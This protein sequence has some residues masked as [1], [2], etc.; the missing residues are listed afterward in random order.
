[1]SIRDVAA[2]AGVSPATVSRVFTQP[3]A[4]APKTRRRVLAAAGELRYTPHPV[5][6][7]LARGRSGNVGIVVP[8]IANAYSAAI[9]KAVQQE[10][11]RDEY[12]LFVAGSDELPQDEVQWARAL[13]PQVDGLLLVSPLM[14]DDDLNELAGLTP[15]VLV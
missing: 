8:D 13:A 7:S 10:V 2:A 12:A 14:S 6:R 1:M 3:D 9:T 5:A 11:R 15:L 4:V